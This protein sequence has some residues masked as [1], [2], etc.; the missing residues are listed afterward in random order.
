MHDK[1]VFLML[2]EKYILMHFLENSHLSVQKPKVHIDF[3]DKFRSQPR[4]LRSA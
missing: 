4:Y 2:A 3:F 1:E